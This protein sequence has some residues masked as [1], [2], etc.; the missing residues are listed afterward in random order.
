MAAEVGQGSTEDRVPLAV[1]VQ[2][3]AILRQES[4]CL[5][6]G[7]IGDN[8][9]VAA[10]GMRD[11]PFAQGQFLLNRSDQQQGVAFCPFTSCSEPEVLAIEVAAS[12]ADGRGSASAA[13]MIRR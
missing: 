6:Q 12:L 11:A 2:P 4:A 8:S 10:G 7:R 13:A 9:A 5:A 1:G 3:L